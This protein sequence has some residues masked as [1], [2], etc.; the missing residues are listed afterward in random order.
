MRKETMFGWVW[1]SFLGFGFMGVGTL[2]LR[3]GREEGEGEEEE[4]EE[5]EGG[6]DKERG[7]RLDTEEIRR[8]MINYCYSVVTASA[9]WASLLFFH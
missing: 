8:R 3:M 5:E 6:V 4:G 7:D 9:V 2:L 1:W